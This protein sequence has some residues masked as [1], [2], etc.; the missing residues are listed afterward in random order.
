MQDP[1]KKEVKTIAVLV[2]ASVIFTI[3]SVATWVAA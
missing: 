2:I 3:L 1:D